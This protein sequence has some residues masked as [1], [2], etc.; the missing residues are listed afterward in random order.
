MGG[1]RE[2]VGDGGREMRDLEDWRERVGD[3]GRWW[4]G[5]ERLGGL[6]GEMGGLRER[7][8]DGGRE[9][10]DLRENEYSKEMRDSRKMVVVWEVVGR[11]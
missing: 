6:E 10:R 7:V 1:L 3:G 9:M 11:R 4:E 5:D 8:G 2:R